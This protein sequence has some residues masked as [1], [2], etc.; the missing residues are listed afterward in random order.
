M[1]II[2]K[3]L[4]KMIDPKLTEKEEKV[5]ELLLKGYNL[6]QIMDELNFTRS[7]VTYARDRIFIKKDVYSQIELLAKR[8]AELE[9]I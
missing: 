7:A 9:E 4:K 8:I 6:T 1:S 5:Y 2:L 3:E